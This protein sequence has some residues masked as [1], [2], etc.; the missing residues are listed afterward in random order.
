MER[1]PLTG[2]FSVLVATGDDSVF[3]AACD[4]PFIKGELIRH[5]IS[6]FERLG[7]SLRPESG[8]R[9]VDAVVPVFHGMTEP[10]FG[11]YSRNCIEVIEEM[12]MRGQ[13]S[14]Q[15][16]LNRVNVF[17]VSEEE[18]REKDPEGRSFVNINT[19]EDYEKIGGAVCSG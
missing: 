3:V 4:M 5:I 10:L 15:E 17:Y 6:S 11:V 16:M 14:I 9:P 12:Y 7:G 1:G 8:D 18:V 19:M 13:K 2:I